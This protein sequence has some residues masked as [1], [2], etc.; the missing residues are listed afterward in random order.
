MMA[1]QAIAVANTMLKMR[2]SRRRPCAAIET[3]DELI[4]ASLRGASLQQ[5][6]SVIER[7][8]CTATVNR[9]RPEPLVQSLPLARSWPSS[10]RNSA[11]DSTK[12]QGLS[13]NNEP[14]GEKSLE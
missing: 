8:R 11:A 2:A 13:R 6:R 3:I 10:G 5:W 12:T 7:E 1:T 14:N 4:L 9:R